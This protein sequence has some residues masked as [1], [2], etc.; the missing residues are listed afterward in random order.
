[1]YISGRGDL[2]TID[3]ETFDFSQLEEYINDDNESN[4]SKTEVS[5]PR[6]D[7]PPFAVRNVRPSFRKPEAAAATPPPPLHPLRPATKACHR[8][9][10]LIIHLSH[11]APSPRQSG[12]LHPFGLDACPGPALHARSHTDPHFRSQYTPSSD[13]RTRTSVHGVSCSLSWQELKIKA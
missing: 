7:S 2:G 9:L 8:R 4:I 13:V 1:M 10:H 12:P 11:L 3:S 5:V 6:I